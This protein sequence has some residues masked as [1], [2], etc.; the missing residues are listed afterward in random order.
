M[1]S[2]HGIEHGPLHIGNSFVA[3]SVCRTHGNGTRIYPYCMS[4]LIASHSIWW[5]ILLNLDV[6]KDGLGSASNKCV[7]LSCLPM[8]GFNLC[9]E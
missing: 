4:W 2:L 7:R 9:K 5:A 3:L 6:G 1:E 8:G